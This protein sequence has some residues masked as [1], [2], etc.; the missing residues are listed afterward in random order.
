[1]QLME[2]PKIRFQAFYMDVVGAATVGSHMEMG[3]LR[4]VSNLKREAR[5]P[6]QN[7]LDLGEPTMGAGAGRSVQGTETFAVSKD[8]SSEPSL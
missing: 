6:G 3:I 4:L 5:P 2:A 8:F 1:M 7:A